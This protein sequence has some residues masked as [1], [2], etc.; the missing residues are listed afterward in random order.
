MV[1]WYCVL[2]EASALVP[3]WH[4]TI[5]RS[6][7]DSHRLTAENNVNA[8]RP[9]VK[10]ELQDFTLA[11]ISCRFFKSFFLVHS[12]FGFLIAIGA[13]KHRSGEIQ[14]LC[15][16]RVWINIQGKLSKMGME[17]GVDSQFARTA[18]ILSVNKVLVY[19]RWWE[20]ITNWFPTWKSEAFFQ[21]FRLNVL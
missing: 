18:G 9:C 12:S 7:R 17:K 8:L 3:G 4:K 20:T 16:L 11:S 2:I 10:C 5:W 13:V 19:S 15:Y 21:L 1:T 14:N 6:K